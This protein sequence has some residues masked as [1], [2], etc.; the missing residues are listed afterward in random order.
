MG[1]KVFLGSADERCKK[2]QFK[3]CMVESAFTSYA[4]RANTK[5]NVQITSCWVRNGMT[6]VRQEW[7]IAVKSK[8]IDKTGLLSSALSHNLDDNNNIRFL[9]HPMEENSE[10][11]M[12]DQR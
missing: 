9:P 1:R 4:K 6:S 3:L 12:L 8:T 10:K 11:K 5:N 7:T 2:A